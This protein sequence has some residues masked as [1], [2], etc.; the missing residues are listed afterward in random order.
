MAADDLCGTC[1]ARQAAVPQEY[2]DLRDNTFFCTDCGIDHL[3]VFFSAA[4]RGKDPGEARRCIGREGAV[5]LCEHET[6]SYGELPW[7]TTL[8]KSFLSWHRYGR[9]KACSDPSH[10]PFFHNPFPGDDTH[11]PSGYFRIHGSYAFLDLEQV[12]HIRIPE[13][14]DNQ[15]ADNVEQLLREAREGGGE[16][17]VPQ[18]APGIPPEMALFSPYSCC[19]LERDGQPAWANE[20]FPCSLARKRGDAFPRTARG[21]W[22]ETSFGTDLPRDGGWRISV[23]F[24]GR[25]DCLRLEYRRVIV[26]AK[27]LSFGQQRRFQR[28][29]P[30][31]FDAIAPDSYGLLQDNA[32]RGLSWC[33]NGECANYYRYSERPI[34]GNRGD[35]VTGG[36][37]KCKEKIKSLFGRN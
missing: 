19:C 31:W 22:T 3:K 15:S 23:R 30:M 36:L 4:E 2:A 33:E 29:D 27:M 1:Q 5:R 14:E 24:C 35:I 16:Y 12:V 25:K 26:I 21:H 28:V 8:F 6:I 11:Q 20:A 32:A 37:R 13:T 10:E 17:I 9:V 34:L 7:P 18:A